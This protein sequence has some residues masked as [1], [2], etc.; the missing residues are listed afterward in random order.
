MM[1]QLTQAAGLFIGERL[2]PGHPSNPEGHF[3][4]LD[5]YELSCAILADDGF[6]ASGLVSEVKV[7]VPAQRRKQ[8]EELVARRRALGVPWGWKDPRSVLLLDFW[9]ELLPE[10]H[11]LFTFRAP[12]DVM[13][14]LYRRGDVACQD[15]PHLPL[16]VWLHYNRCVQ[17]FV[18]AHPARC[19]LF[20]VG[21]LSADPARCIELVASRIGIGLRAEARTVRP[22]LMLRAETD[23]RVTL[24]NAVSPSSTRLYAELCTMAGLQAAVPA[25]PSV[26]APAHTLENAL[27]QWA[28]SRAQT[29]G[30]ES[31]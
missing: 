6:P 23:D 27:V 29:Q 22:E 9:A 14:S 13:D 20:E 26:R 17:S 28:R 11:F 30:T 25:Q 5:F 4:D 24:V 21:Q 15:D 10:A 3:E 31:A 18:H 16:R 1:A 2:M 7:A 8:A 19:S 12:W